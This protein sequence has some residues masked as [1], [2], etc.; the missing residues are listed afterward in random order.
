MDDGVKE[1]NTCNGSQMQTNN[2]INRP[3]SEYLPSDALTADPLENAI[4][5]R[6]ML[7]D[8]DSDDD[9][10]EENGL[11][12]SKDMMDKLDN[13]SWLRKELADGGLRQMI[14]TIDNADGENKKNEGSNRKRARINQALE[15]SPREVAL[16][17]AKHTNHKF[18]KFM[19]KLLLT[20]GVLVENNG[21]ADDTITAL[22][23]GDLDTNNLSMVSIPSKR[24]PNHVEEDENSTDSSIQNESEPDAELDLGGD[25]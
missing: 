24:R 8:S 14:A 12:I 19:D 6:R 22:L 4:R 25:H 23:K 3:A 10:L 18:R 9:S 7:D 16:E 17:R 11:R 20:A 21:N 2:S 5:R 1:G 15:L 13:S